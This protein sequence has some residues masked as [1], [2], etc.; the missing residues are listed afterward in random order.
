MT[1]DRWKIP[2]KIPHGYGAEEILIS[3]L[4]AKVGALKGALR[5][6]MGKVLLIP[7]SKS[8]VDSALDDV[9]ELAAKSW[10][11]TLNKKVQQ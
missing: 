3:Q 2:P 9:D 6:E 4:Y 8:K 5:N 1:G 7:V 10:I 11:E